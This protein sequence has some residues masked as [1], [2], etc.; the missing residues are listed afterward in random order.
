MINYLSNTSSGEKKPTSTFPAF[1]SKPDN[2]HLGSFCDFN[3]AS[4][5]ES[6]WK[7]SV[8]TIVVSKPCLPP[9]QRVALTSH[10]DV[11][12]W[13]RKKR[14]YRSPLLGWVYREE[15]VRKS[16]SM[17]RKA[18]RHRILGHPFAR[19]AY[20]TG[21]RSGRICRQCVRHFW[22]WIWMTTTRESCCRED[23]TWSMV[24]FVYLV[25]SSKKKR[26]D[27]QLVMLQQYQTR[28]TQTQKERR[29][30]GGGKLT[31]VWI[32]E[33]SIDFF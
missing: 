21:Q 3:S 1:Q 8:G 27:M 23:E 13:W 22:H 4:F 14:K 25:W 16:N 6:I 26:R 28:C 29:K 32:V 24:V 30:H 15:K 19:R 5:W 12:R 9:R 2:E 33:L 7:R 17:M 18:G 31:I 10:F 20:D 11:Y